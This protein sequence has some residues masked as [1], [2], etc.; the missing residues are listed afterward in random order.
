VGGETIE[1]GKPYA[2]IFAAACHLSHAKPEQVMMMGDNL[3]T[4][5]AGANRMG[6]SSLLVLKHGLH[7]GLSDSALAEAVRSHGATP[8]YIAPAF[9]W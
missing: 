3:A 8:T 6:L 2:P 1:F 4:D 9:S 5:I 7:G